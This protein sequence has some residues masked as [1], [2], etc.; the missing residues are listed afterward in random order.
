MPLG[1]HT[2]CRG[3][4]VVLDR[5]CASCNMATSR[6]QPASSSST[7]EPI[8]Q[9]LASLLAL[10]TVVET[11]DSRCSVHT[12][13]IGCWCRLLVSVAGIGSWYRKLVILL[14]IVL[15][16]PHLPAFTPSR[17]DARMRTPPPSSFLSLLCHRLPTHKKINTPKHN[18]HSPSSPHTLR[19][20]PYATAFVPRTSLTHLLQVAK[21]HQPQTTRAALCP[22]STT[23]SRGI[24]SPSRPH[25]YQP[26]HLLTRTLAAAAG[27]QICRTPPNLLQRMSTMVH[28]HRTT[29]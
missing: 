11:L 16:V 27:S 7:R 12:L 6:S 21:H 4:I 23:W 13:P 9:S 20:K 18:C 25:L 3:G 26:E 28:S 14:L 19:Q 2:P 24:T 15:L 22:T 29:E 8:S 1:T 10:P 17:L 5:R